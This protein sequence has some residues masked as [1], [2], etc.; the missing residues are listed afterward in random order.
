M[1]SHCHNNPVF[2]QDPNL[3][4]GIVYDVDAF[5]VT[6]CPHFIATHVYYK[7]YRNGISWRRAKLLMKHL[8]MNGHHR[9]TNVKWSGMSVKVGYSRKRRVLFF[10]YN[11]V[12]DVTSR[13]V[14]EDENKS[15]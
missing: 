11:E 5:L 12:L 10:N 3:N 7:S 15:D 8:Y 4:Y 2:T 13:E 1:C 14:I 9:K 6:K